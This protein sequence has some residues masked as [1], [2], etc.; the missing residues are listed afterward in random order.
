M[1]PRMASLV[2][3]TWLMACGGTEAPQLSYAGWAERTAEAACAHAELCGGLTVPREQC[4]AD[5]ISAYAE[6]EPELA[7]GDTGAKAGCVQCM[8]IRTEE[9]DAAT[10]SGC[11]QA[12]DEARLLAVCGVDNAACAGVP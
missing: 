1:N 10:A 11:Q 2:V 4:E 8:R 5:L 7:R 3:S 12:P 6:V 9:L